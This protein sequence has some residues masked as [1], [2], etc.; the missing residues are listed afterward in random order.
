MADEIAKTNIFVENL[1]EISKPDN[2]QKYILGYRKN[3]YPRA[4]YD[5]VRECTGIKKKKKKKHKKDKKSSINGINFYTN[6]K[7]DKKKKKKKK[8]KKHWHI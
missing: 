2:F 6:V 5:V 4:V 8:Y 3:G 7:K 1:K